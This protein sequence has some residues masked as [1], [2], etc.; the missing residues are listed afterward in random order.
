MQDL[1]PHNAPVPSTIWRERALVLA[2]VLLAVLARLIPSPRT[3]DDAFITF[4]YARNIVHGAGFVYN[5]GEHVL[6]TTTPLY[7]LWM[8]ALALITRSEAYSVFAL[9]T[10]ALADAASVYLL[11]H[12]GRRLSHSP[13]V[14]MAVALLWAVA[15]MS[16]TFAIG[17]METSVFI[18]LMLATFTAHL[19]RHSYAAAILAA[20]ALLTRPDAALIVVLVFGQVLLENLKSQISNLETPRAPLK[21]VKLP[22]PPEQPGSNGLGQEAPGSPRKRSAIA[23][24]FQPILVFVLVIAPWVIFATLYFGNPLSQSVFAKSVAYRLPP[25]AGL[26]RLIQHFSVPF[27]ESDVFDLAGLIRLVFYLAL[28]AIAALTAFRR[29]PRSLPLFAYPPLYAAA[30]ALVNPLLFR[31]YLAPPLPAYFLGILLGVYQVLNLAV[32]PSPQVNEFSSFALHVPRLSLKLETRHFIYG[33]VAAIF[34]ITSLRA[35]TLHPDHGPGRPAPQMAFVKLELLY[36]QVAADLEPHIRAQTVIAAGD[37]GA[38]GYDTNARILDTLGL[39]S[40]QTLRY[41][42][43]DPNLYAINYAMSPQLIRN[44]QPDWLVAPEVY[45]R[46]GV[47]KDTQ[48]QS[49]YRLVEKI[50]TDIYGSDGLLVYQHK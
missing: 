50:P 39:I 28:Y 36:H 48:F 8:A 44:Q 30:F 40:P 14:G 11:Y 49:Q 47:L 12:L 5:T 42:P 17:G 20:L 37:I 43:L 18:L 16:V 33:A 41:Y 10:N 2:L 46:N 7:T 22:F 15:P 24:V 21:F 9:V 25:Q 6:G 1:R 27:F 31:W 3:I 29:E 38:L 13:L 45:L 32:R 35:W 23:S 34:L 26:V 19:E 4:R